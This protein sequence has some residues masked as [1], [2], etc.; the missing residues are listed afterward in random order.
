M[1]FGTLYELTKENL[2]D[3]TLIYMGGGNPPCSFFVTAQKL[4]ALDC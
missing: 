4:L 2:S 3:L 1:T